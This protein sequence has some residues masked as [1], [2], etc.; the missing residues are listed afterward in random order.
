MAKAGD[1]SFSTYEAYETAARVFLVPRFG[2]ARF[3]QL[4]VGRRCDRMLQDILATETLS[5]ARPSRA[6]RAGPPLRVC[7]A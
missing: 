6:D 4:T 7:R 5:K 1:I 2:A 3:E